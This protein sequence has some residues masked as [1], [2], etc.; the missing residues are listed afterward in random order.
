MRM[1]VPV[2]HKVGP[3]GSL[4]QTQPL[5]KPIYVNP[6]IV[7]ENRTLILLSRLYE[8]K[9]SVIILTISST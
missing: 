7:P 5:L 9:K 2:L 1:V 6:G 8:K 4:A 3:V